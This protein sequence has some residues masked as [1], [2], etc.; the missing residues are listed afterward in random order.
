M[1]EPIRDLT[2]PAATVAAERADD[3]KRMRVCVL[4]ASCVVAILLAAALAHVTADAAEAHHA[5]P[6]VLGAV[7]AAAQRHGVDPEP[8]V[9]LVRC[10]SRGDAHAEGDKRWRYYDGAGWRFV[11][12]SRGAAQLN[13]LPTGL[14][15]HFW[16][17]GYD[18]RE[19]PEQV[20]DYI[21]RVRKGEFLPGRPNAPPLHPHG[22]V[23]IDRW[24][25]WPLVA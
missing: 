3:D 23:S 22:V 20:A 5:Q 24:S 2:G 4:L 16:S 17:L 25:C 14:A 13:D 6:D 10:E 18:D 8:L 9:R 19:D 7:Y 21:A 11:P 1:A 12:T 15:R